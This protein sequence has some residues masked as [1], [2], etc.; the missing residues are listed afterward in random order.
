MKKRLKILILGCGGFIGSHLTKS[1]IKEKNVVIHGLD[2][3]KSNILDILKFKNFIF[4]KGDVHQ[5]QKWVEKKIKI[6]DVIIPLIAIATPNTYVKSPL[7]VFELDFETNLEVVRLVSKYKKRLIFPSSSEVYGL[8]KDKHFKEYSTKLTVGP[9]H[10]SRWIYSI[11]K[12]LLDRIIFAYAQKKNLKFT[13]FR[14]FNWIGPNLDSLEKAQMGN[15]RVLSIF[16]SNILNKKSLQLVSAGKQKRSFT[17]IDDGISA[18]KKIIFGNENKLNYKIFNIGNPKN[19][20]TIKKLASLVKKEFLINSKK[21]KKIN[22]I[23]TTEEKFFGKGYE[24]METRKP[25]IIEAKKILKWQ[26]KIG[27]KKAIKLIV[28]HYIKKNES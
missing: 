21:F 14:P 1:L 5:N 16:I 4:K 8:S 22:I 6:C 24:D 27:Y 2:L 9:V 23:N 15:G 17:F 12:Q 26:P 13:I 11:S 7:R 18:L 28:M 10:K 20:I 19:H 25:S 3:D